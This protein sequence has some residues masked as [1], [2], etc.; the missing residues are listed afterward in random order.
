MGL[1]EAIVAAVSKTSFSI[2]SLSGRTRLQKCDI[3]NFCIL[4]PEIIQSCVQG[5][6]SGMWC[7]HTA[8]HYIV[9]LIAIIQ[10]GPGFANLPGPT[11]KKA[12]K[13]TA[14][15]CYINI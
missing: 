11:K 1:L 3:S 12:I 15:E 14:C 5:K 8:S 4:F 9:I 10:V 6:H 2:V 13:M 7:T